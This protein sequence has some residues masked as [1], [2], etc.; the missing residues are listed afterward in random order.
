MNPKFKDL[1]INSLLFLLED[2]LLRLRHSPENLSYKFVEQQ[3][4]RALE[5]QKEIKF[6]TGEV[7]Q[8][9]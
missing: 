8:L 7:T 6:R 2:C 5:I 9:Q 1:D 4:D 3:A